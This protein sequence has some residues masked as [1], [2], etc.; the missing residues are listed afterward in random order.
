MR[1][2]L[3]FLFS[4]SSSS[5]TTPHSTLR[6][7]K[8]CVIQ[9]THFYGSLSVYSALFASGDMTTQHIV[10]KR[11]VDTRVINDNW[12]QVCVQFT[13]EYCCSPEFDGHSSG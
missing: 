13:S 3:T 6:F 1:Q 8:K 10:H 2:T 11:N 4:I 12:F 5:A 9:G 7:T